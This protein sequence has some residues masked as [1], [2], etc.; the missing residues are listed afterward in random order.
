M[1]GYSC[2]DEGVSFQKCHLAR[3]LYSRYQV[4]LQQG[5]HP[6]ARYSCHLRSSAVNNI[7]F[8][9]QDYIPGTGSF[10]CDKVFLSRWSHLR[11]N[12]SSS[13]DKFLFEGQGLLE[14][15]SL[16]S[17]KVFLSRWGRLLSKWS[18]SSDKVMFQRQVFPMTRSTSRDQ[19]FV[20]R[21]CLLLARRSSSCNNVIFQWEGHLTTRSFS[22]DKVCISR[23]IFC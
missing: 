2:Y 7:I 5:L 4:F 6:S 10:S 9:R 19:V 8:L 22:R 20:S 23:W 11:A 16:F 1:V 14:A 18:F 13:S 3:R 21:R 17:G 15:R 12:E